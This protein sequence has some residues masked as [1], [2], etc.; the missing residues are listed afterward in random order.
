MRD[1]Y[2]PQ[3]SSVHLAHYEHWDSGDPHIDFAVE[4][5]KLQERPT[6]LF[7]EAP[8]VVL[9]KS[10]GALLAFIAIK[11]TVLQPQACVFFGT[12]FDLAAHSVFQDSWSPVAEFSVPAIAFHNRNDPTADYRFTV[13]TLAQHAPQVELITT[14]Q[15]DHWYGDTDTYDPYIEKFL[16]S[17]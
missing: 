5:R 13:A 17:L 7:A 14:H 6:P 4:L 16:Q 2:G 11:N 1:H 8:V 15:D 3:F 10:A 9:A 12:P